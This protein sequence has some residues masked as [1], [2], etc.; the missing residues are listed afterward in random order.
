MAQKYQAAKAGD[1]VQEAPKLTNTFLQDYHLRSVLKRLLPENVH[2]AVFADLARFGD[3]CAG[4]LRIKARECEVIPPELEQYDGWGNRVDRVTTCA[5]W[6]SMKG[7][8]AEEGLVA[9][10]YERPYAEYSRLV[11][12]AKLLL[13]APSSGLYSCPLAMTDGAAKVLEGLCGGEAGTISPAGRGELEEAFSRLVSRDARRFATSG[14]WMTE[15]RGGSDVASGTDTYA[16]KE[17]AGEASS[18][19]SS[20]TT[21]RLYGLKWFT[22]ATDADMSITLARP[23]ADKTSPGRAQD[24]AMF[25]LW[26]RDSSGGLNGL[27]VEKLKKKL[28]T[29]QLPTGELVLDGA[30]ALQIS[31]PGE[32]IARIMALAN[33]TRL[34]NAVSASAGMRRMLQL[35]RDYAFRRTVLGEVLGNNP[36]HLRT[37]AHMEVEA[38][39]GTALTLEVA[40]LLGQVE[41]LPPGSARTKTAANL[42]RVLT[43]MAKLLTGKQA[44]SVASEGLEAFGGAGYLEDTGLPS[45]LRDA[46]VLPIWEGTT[47]VNALDVFRSLQRGK[48]AIFEALSAEVRGKLSSVTGASAAHVPTVLFALQVCEAFAQEHLSGTPSSRAVTAIAREFAMLLARTYTAAILLEH[49][50]WAQAFEGDLV[51]ARRWVQ[52]LAQSGLISTVLLAVSESSSPPLGTAGLE[53]LAQQSKLS[54]HHGLAPSAAAASDRSLKSGLRGLLQEDR[55]LVLEGWGAGEGRLSS[56]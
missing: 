29:R 44:V 51:A 52:G 56:L 39:G 6:Q 45:M 41:A 47:N 48:G 21:H 23:V 30:R 3:R 25:F 55:I 36:L 33:I 26:T 7:V 31:A 9:L 38:R 11:Q 40:L 15:R 34:H 43:P 5:A 14:Q 32:G 37:L 12:A 19:S 17:E 16:V 50:S 8:C 13:F 22:S 49:S 46:Q 10:A 4:E 35:C 42:L 20:S 2:G 24:L 1:F 53:D 27:S 18:S 28:G 54:G